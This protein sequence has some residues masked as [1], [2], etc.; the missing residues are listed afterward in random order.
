[1]SGR[2]LRRKIST[3]GRGTKDRARKDCRKRR[4][5]GM[6]TAEAGPVDAPIVCLV[7]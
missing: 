2:G 7:A 6:L 3:D 5:L 1:M 4:G